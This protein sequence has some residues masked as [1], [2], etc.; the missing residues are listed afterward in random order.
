MANT[1][2]TSDAVAWQR[3]G[4]VT[5]VAGLAAVVLLFVVLVGSRAEPSFSA[6]ADEFLTHYR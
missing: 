6:G 2:P 4:K 3:L 1:A 5:G